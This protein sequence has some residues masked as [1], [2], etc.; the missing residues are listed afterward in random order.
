MAEQVIWSAAAREDLRAIA[1]RI[2]QDRP[3]LAE[4]YCLQ[5]IAFAETAGA[6][7]H[8]GRTMPELEDENVREIIRPPYR[9]IYELSPHQPR[10]VILR[11]WHGARG[12]P[13]I[14]RPASP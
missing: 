4:A 14:S 8:L 11:I 2:A 7:P 9:I 6:F 1:T 5:L 3:A 12:T 13:E 10:P